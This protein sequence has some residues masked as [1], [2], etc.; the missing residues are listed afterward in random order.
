MKRSDLWRVVALLLPVVAVTSVR[1][2][3]AA[4]KTKRMVGADPALDFLRRK[5][6]HA[7]P[8][9]LIALDRGGADD[10]EHH[11]AHDSERAT[12]KNGLHPINPLKIETQ[13]SVR[14]FSNR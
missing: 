7:A 12:Q 3:R 6:L 8:H 5:Q 14:T 2:L 4:A 11:R 10:P 9:Q 1:K 13:T